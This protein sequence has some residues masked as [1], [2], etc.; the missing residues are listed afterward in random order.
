M[1]MKVYTEVKNKKRATDGN[2]ANEVLTATYFLLLP[3]TEL[4]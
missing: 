1:S 2:I 4:I 3:D